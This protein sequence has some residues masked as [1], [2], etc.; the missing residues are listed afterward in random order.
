MAIHVLIHL[1]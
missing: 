1:L